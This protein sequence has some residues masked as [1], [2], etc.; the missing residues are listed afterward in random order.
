MEL[1][2]TNLKLLLVCCKVYVVEGRKLFLGGTASDLSRTDKSLSWA[3]VW[4]GADNQGTDFYTEGQFCE[5][6]PGSLSQYPSLL[7]LR[8]KGDC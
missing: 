7:P 3:Q 4:V 8:F 1:G 6:N 2:V 5:I